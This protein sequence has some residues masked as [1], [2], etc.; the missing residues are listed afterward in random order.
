MIRGWVRHRLT[1]AATAGGDRGAVMFWVVPIMIGLIAMAGLIVDGGNAISARERAEDVSQQAA[2]AGAD[3]LS[4]IALHDSDHSALTADPWAA[5][6]AAQRVLDSAGISNPTVVVNG[7]SVTVSVT[8]HEKTQVLSAFGL[9]DIS[10]SASS[11]ATAL[12][13][14]NTGG[15]G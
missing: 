7:D 4:P 15:T 14:S 11:T 9:N 6:A 3:A 13:G 10:G 5:R 1:T 2:R 12:H 8:V